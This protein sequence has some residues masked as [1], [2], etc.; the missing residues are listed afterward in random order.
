MTQPTHEIELRGCAP[1]PLA[2]YLKALGILRLVSEQ[3]DPQA[4]GWWQHDTFR[5]RSTLDEKEVA[6]FFLERYQALHVLAYVG[7]RKCGHADL[8]GGCC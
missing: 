4:Q 3:A 5:L 1:T 8:I 7:L 2:H 6:E